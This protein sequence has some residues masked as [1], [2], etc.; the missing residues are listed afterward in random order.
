M[1]SF[2]KTTTSLLSLCLALTVGAESQSPRWIDATAEAGL[3]HQEGQRLKFADLNGN[4]R[5]DAILMPAGRT[6]GPVRI[7]LHQLRD[8]DDPT[9]F[10]YEH[11]EETGLPVLHWA[12]ILVFADI[13]NNGILDAIL[14]RHLDIYQENYSPPQSDPQVS[15]WFPGNGDGTFAEPE[16]LTEAKMATTL[17]IAI[18]DVNFSGQLDIFMGLGYERYFTG[19]E[20]FVNDLLL[21]YETV[22]GD[23]AFKRW[24]MPDETV[25]TD[26]TDDL[27]GRP[28]YGVAIARF[29]DGLPMLIEMNYGRRWNRLYQL[30]FRES[31]RE[32]DWGDREPPGP[33]ISQD[34]RARGQHLV[35][36]LK[37]RNIAAEA[38]VDGDHI[39]HGQHPEWP[40]AAQVMQPRV[41]RA[42]E[43]PFR[44]NGNTFDAAIGDIN[45]NGA[46]DLFL[47]TI[48]HGW[49]GDSSDRSRFL[50]NQ[51]SNSG[52]LKFIYQERLSV[53]RIPPL[54]EPGEEKE[55]IHYNF[56]QGD[57]FAELADLN[58]NGRLDLILASSDYRDP[59]PYEERLRIFLQTDDGRFRDATHELGLDHIGAGSPSL[60]DVNGNGALDILVGQ[61]FNRL[62]QE[63]RRAAAIVSGALSPDSP[64]DA[65]AETRVRLFLNDLTEGRKS[66]IL[67]LEGDP[68][69]GIAR[70]SIGA[71]IRMTTDLDSDPETEDVTQSRQ[72]IGPSGHAGKQHQFL[73]HFGLGEADKAKHLKISWP[74]RAGTVTEYHDLSAGRYLVRPDGSIEQ[75]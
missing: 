51:L 54:P 35:S 9:S 3:D 57:I 11:L 10:Y 8:A 71:I 21:Q 15:A 40:H 37:G 22:D 41:R 19:Y 38:Q 60:A 62:T 32:I 20:A 14:G 24:P 53:D 18:A 44:A 23:V 36:E 59:P 68:E 30:S 12:D 75:R 46:F 27:G 33:F 29:D 26:Y 66:I 43:P 64:E 7:Y 52:E 47:S 16:I 45:N 49:A 56:N 65:R 13:N 73:V 69:M 5:P 61:S 4:Q 25:P 6:E 39:R 67:E 48:I 74:N 28:S 17:A 50:V 58:H 42:D 1:I 70:D 55:W 34:P 63:Q 2:N 31:L 72:L